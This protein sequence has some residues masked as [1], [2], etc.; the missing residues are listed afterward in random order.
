MARAAAERAERAVVSATRKSSK[1]T[2][3][4]RNGLRRRNQPAAP[5]DVDDEIL[6]A[7]AIDHRR[8]G[9]SYRRI[10]DAM[11]HEMRVDA[12][13]AI[14]VPLD[15][16]QLL[17]VPDAKRTNAQQVAYDGARTI[18]RNIAWR[19]VIEALTQMRKENTENADELRQIEL[20]RLDDYVDRLNANAE[21]RADPRTVDTLL[22]VGESRRKLLGLDAEVSTRL[23]LIGA[24]GGAVEIALLMRD[25]REAVRTKLN[26]LATAIS[27]AT[28]IVVADT[29]REKTA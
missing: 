26:R 23:R 16:A 6:R 22:R 19:L 21:R 14:G 8:D 17:A 18:G 10:A 29:P 5:K 2:H 7:R 24:D 11:T 4:H 15:K 20:E 13:V 25:A 12:L 3:A 28:P 9:K 1:R 27:A